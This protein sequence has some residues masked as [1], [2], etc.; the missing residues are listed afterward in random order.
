MELLSGIGPLCAAA[1]FVFFLLL[2]FFFTHVKHFYPTGAL[3]VWI[4]LTGLA[5]ID[6][7]G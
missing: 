4:D 5:W 6:R 1:V 7:M 2:L 3:H